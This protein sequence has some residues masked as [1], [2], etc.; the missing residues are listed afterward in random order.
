[1]RSITISTHFAHLDLGPLIDGAH[2]FATARRGRAL[3]PASQ[4]GGATAATQARQPG[5][6]HGPGAGHLCA[7]LAQRATA[8]TARTPGLPEHRGQP[9]VRA[10]FPPPGPGAR[11]P[12]DPRA[13]GTAAPAF[14]GNPTAGTRGAGRR[15]PGTGRPGQPGARGVSAV[16]ARRPD[17]SADC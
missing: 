3:P 1:M 10:V 16:P 15:G 7:H 12:G 13:A 8:G 5:P 4:L 9:P 6:G 14:A 11:V 17:L 2:P